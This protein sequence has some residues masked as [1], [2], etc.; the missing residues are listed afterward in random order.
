MIA[1]TFNISE[2]Y[3]SSLFKEQ[4][5]I[6]FTDYVEKQRIRK[7]C[8]LLKTTEMN[9]NEISEKVGY[10]SVQSFRRA[11]KRLHGFKPSELRKSHA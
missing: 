3:V 10:N 6:N 11:F 1:T 2:G 4:A 5:G 7:A 8:E 9:I